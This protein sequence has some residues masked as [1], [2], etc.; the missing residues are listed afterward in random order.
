MKQ[1]MV[2]LEERAAKKRTLVLEVMS[3]VGLTKLEKPDFTASVRA[4]TPS[5]VVTS[6]DVIP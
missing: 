5:L 4:G 3:E 6:E 2:R 1:R